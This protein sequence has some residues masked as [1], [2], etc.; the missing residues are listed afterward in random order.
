MGHPEVIFIDVE[1]SSLHNGYPIEIGWA[2]VRD[3]EVTTESCLIRPTEKW[4]SQD[5]RWSSDAQAVHK[6]VLH[7]LINLGKPVWEVK[8]RMTS[9]FAGKVLFSD[10]AGFDFN[11]ITEL[12]H[13]E[14]P[15]GPAIPFKLADIS[16]AF[17]GAD[18]DERKYD[19]EARKRDRYLPEHRAADDALN[20]ALM[21]C[22]SRRNIGVAQFRFPP[23]RESWK[24]L[25]E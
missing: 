12:Y 1:A 3:L 18:T 19:R 21:W 14:A 22:Y 13:A 10:A 2:I 24:Y 11:W 17:A 15:V 23:T 8:A 4:L 7:D 25:L 6:I 9:L 20:H 16:V 5:W